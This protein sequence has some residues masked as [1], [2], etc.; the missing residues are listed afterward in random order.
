MQPTLAI[1]TG[2]SRGIG[3][4]IALRLAREGLRVALL[5]RSADQLADVRDEILADALANGRT[6]DPLVLPCDL[7]DER[8]TVDAINQIVQ[9]ATPSVL[10]NNAG[11]GGPVQNID[12]VSGSD[13]D[14][15]F[16]LNVRA[17]YVLCRHILPQMAMHGSGTIINIGSTHSHIGAAGS[18]AYCASKHALLGMTRALAAEW[19]RR[20]ITCNAVCPGYTR[21]EMVGTFADD[22]NLLS[23]IP[24]GRVGTPH[25][26]AELVAFLCSPA[27]KAING[28]A[29]NIDG[30]MLADLGL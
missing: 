16:G 10:V 8:A 28:A 12:Q 24:T 14:R 17:A 26:V 20:G 13:W 7:L 15:V 1:V 4:A 2:A 21:T 27:A 25:E 9:H 19:G 11:Y 30:G 18:V 5:A 22:P 29:L 6:T 3:R 23:R